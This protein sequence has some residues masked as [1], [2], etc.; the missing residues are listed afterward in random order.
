MRSVDTNIKN[1]HSSKWF[2]AYFVGIA[3]NCG[4]YLLASRNQ[5]YKV[6]TV[7]ANTEDASFGAQILEEVAIEW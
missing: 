6:S 1:D 5:I 4:S 7:K 3:T 2:E